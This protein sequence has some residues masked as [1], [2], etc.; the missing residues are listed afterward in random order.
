MRSGILEAVAIK[1]PRCGCSDLYNKVFFVVLDLG[2]EYCVHLCDVLRCDQISVKS[3]L[4]N[5]PT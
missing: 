1:H 2:V 5:M 3:L 4:E